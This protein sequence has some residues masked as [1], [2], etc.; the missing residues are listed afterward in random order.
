MSLSLTIE[1]DLLRDMFFKLRTRD[2]ILELLDVDEQQLIYYLYIRPEQQRYRKIFLK[3][4]TGGYRIISS[5]AT[6]LKIVQRKFLQVLETVYEAKPA[7]HGFV[8]GKSIVSNARMHDQK[9]YVLNI[10][11][12]D[13]FPSINFG[14]VRGL[15]MAAPY[16]FNEEVATI[17]AQICCHRGS[18]PQGASTSPIISN[19]ICARLDRELLRFAQQ[20]RCTYTRYADD[21]TFST[22]TKKL[23]YNL[24]RLADSTGQIELGADLVSIITDNGFQVHPEKSRLQVMTRRQ[25]VTGLTVNKFPNVRRRFIR[26]IR[27][28][29]YAWKKFDLQ[30]AEREYYERYCTKRYPDFKTKPPFRQVVIGKIE[31]VGMV[32]GKNDHIYL[33]FR[34]MLMDLDNPYRQAVEKKAEEQPFSITPLILTEGKTDWKHLKRAFQ[35]MQERGLFRQMTLEFQER[36]IEAGSGELKNTC[37]YLSRVR[38]GQPV[39][40]IFDRDEPQIMSEVTVNGGMKA[41]GNNVFSFAIP[42]PDHRRETPEVCIELLY[43]DD[44]ITKVDSHG[45]R[46]YLST[47]FVPRSG[48]HKERPELSYPNP[49]KLKPNKLTIIDN[50]VFDM[51]SN[52]VALPKDDFAELVLAGNEPFHDVGVD[53]FKPIFE[54]IVAVIQTVNASEKA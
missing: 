8:P 54:M 19:M 39:I 31:F 30:N 3:K 11:L 28:M 20:N 24:V 44:D 17:L 29:L 35:I 16:R 26:Q 41:W 27:A 49:G 9:T 21:I 4:K 18:L 52:N 36:D 46:L 2:D 1:P 34:D 12:Q 48:R 53:A 7:V 10:D 37:K 33:R 25:E 45:R 43:T 5:P 47:E 42:V 22:T 15:F 38:Q 23:P 51:Y 14:R 32:R 50:T 6:A 13:F 40:A